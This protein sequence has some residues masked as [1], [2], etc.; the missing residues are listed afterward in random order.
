MNEE[1][2]MRYQQCKNSAEI[3]VVEDEIKLDIEGNGQIYQ[4]FHV[5]HR[6]KVD[7]RLGIETTGRFD[8]IINCKFDIV[9]CWE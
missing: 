2:L 5:K 1:I 9:S 3:K 4:K 8:A 7:E 6:E